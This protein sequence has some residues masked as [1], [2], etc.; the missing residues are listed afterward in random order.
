MFRICEQSINQNLSPEQVTKLYE[1]A[2]TTALK[3][4]EADLAKNQT[5]LA[6]EL[7]DPKVR[8]V[9]NQVFGSPP[10]AAS[11]RTP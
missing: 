9:W 6:R 2:I 11:H 5:E 10:S 4:A 3:L 1:L 8:E 7:S